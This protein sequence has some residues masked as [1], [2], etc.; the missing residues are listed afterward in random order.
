MAIAA[1]VLSLVGIVLSFFSGYFSIVALPV[2]IIGLILACI[3]RK[4]AKTGMA[5]AALVLGIIA[6]C[7]S[8]VLFFTCGLC[9]LAAVS[10]L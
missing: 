5:T 6:V 3:S 2:S 9:A 7:L 1:F 8:A 10:L 4:K